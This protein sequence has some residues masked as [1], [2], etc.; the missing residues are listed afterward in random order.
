MV[1]T[2]IRQ[3][4]VLGGIKLQLHVVLFLYYAQA[5]TGATKSNISSSIIWTFIK[6]EIMK[7]L[8]TF[9]ICIYLMSCLGCDKKESE[10]QNNVEVDRYVE[11]LKD[12]SYDSY[13][14]PEFTHKDIPAL[15]EYRNETQMIIDFPV[16]MISSLAMPEC[17]LGIY[18]LWTIES[19]RA[20]A[21][22]SEYLTGRF[23]SQN[24]ILALRDSNESNL[25]SDNLSHMIVAEAY[26]SWWENNKNKNFDDFKNIDPLE[27]TDY[28]WH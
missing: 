25:V 11:L 12:G 2:G 26:Y 19:I 1:K 7:T 8:R 13:E 27:Y 4:N 24:P 15:L 28:K 5:G 22:D 21:I 20:V 17:S 6:L 18:I 3:T 9:I 16:N 10:D 23:P 14:L